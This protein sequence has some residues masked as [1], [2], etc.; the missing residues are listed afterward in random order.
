MTASHRKLE[1]SL[2]VVAGQLL[3]F[4]HQQSRKGCACHCVKDLN[5][6]SLNFQTVLVCKGAIFRKPMK[7]KK[8][9]RV[10]DLLASEADAEIRSRDT[11]ESMQEL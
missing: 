5:L 4:F 10:N 9:E 3:F 6:I 2:I 7:G 1:S 8:K 11:Q